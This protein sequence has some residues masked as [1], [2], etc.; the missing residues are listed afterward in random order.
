MGQ[1]TFEKGN[2]RFTVVAFL[3]LYAVPCCM[4]F[5]SF[6]FVCRAVLLLN[7]AYLF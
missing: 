6:V 4:L 5:S 7:E 3:S 1:Q 2:S